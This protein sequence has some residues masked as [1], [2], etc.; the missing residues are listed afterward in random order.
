MYEDEGFGGGFSLG[1]GGGG[2]WQGGG[3]DSGFSFSAGVATEPAASASAA[4]SGQAAKK[5]VSGKH[6]TAMPCPLLVCALTRVGS[7]VL[8]RVSVRMPWCP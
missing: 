5:A 1:G 3:G 7:L 8:W 2:G 4:S 6:R